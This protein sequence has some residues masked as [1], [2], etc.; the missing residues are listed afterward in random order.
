MRALSCNLFQEV[1]GSGI[2]S[3]ESF[4]DQ[5][6]EEYPLGAAGIEIFS[7]FAGFAM[8]DGGGGVLGG[9]VEEGVLSVT[10]DS[11]SLSIFLLPT[12]CPVSVLGLLGRIERHKFER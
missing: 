9:E 1:D 10:E 6:L 11:P 7:N 3:T 5:G 4:D 12:L 2:P 8:V